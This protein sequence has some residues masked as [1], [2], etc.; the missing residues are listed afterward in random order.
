M[1]AIL[2]KIIEIADGKCAA[3]VARIVGLPKRTVENYM[4]GYRKMSVEFVQKFC[5][6]FKVTPNRVFGYPESP[7]PPQTGGEPSGDCPRCREKDG[8]LRTLEGRLAERD[9]TI[10]H[11]ARALDRQMDMIGDLSKK[12]PEHGHAVPQRRK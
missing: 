1:D 10:G 6:T 8:R 5:E 2:E 4:W 12:Q 11:Q 9:K 3:E 7:A